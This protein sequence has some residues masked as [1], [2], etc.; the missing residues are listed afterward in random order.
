MLGGWDWFEMGIPRLG[1]KGPVSYNCCPQS[2]NR[3]TTP[4]YPVREHSRVVE[5]G[6]VKTRVVAH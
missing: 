2:G 1:T 4:W 5:C 6:V 3:G